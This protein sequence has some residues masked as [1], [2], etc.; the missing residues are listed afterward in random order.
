MKKRILLTFI[1]AVTVAI[2]GCGQQMNQSASQSSAGNTEE[3]AAPETAAS[4]AVTEMD[5][6][7]MFTGR[8]YEVGYKESESAEILLNETSAACSSDAV[9]ISGSTVTITE[10]GT[11]ILR[12][13]LENG[14]VIVDADETDK[15]QLVFDGVSIH[16]ETSAP[17]YILEA[18][19]V[20]ITLP[21]D[22]VNT[23][24]NGGVFTAIDDN[25]IDAAVFSKQDLT[26]NGSGSLTVA[27]PAGHG[28][29][30]KDDLVFT[31][32]T[33]AIDAASHGIDANDSIRITNTAL[34]ITSGKDGIHGENTDD[35]SL[36][37]VYIADGTFHITAE[38]DGLSASSNMQIEDGSFAI[39]AGGGSVNAQKQDSGFGGGFQGGGHRRSDSNTGEASSDTEEESISMKGIKAESNLVVHNGTFNIDAADDAVHSNTSITINGG[40]FEI[41]SGDDGFHADETMTIMAGTINIS[42][43][44]EGLEGL[45]VVI[46]GGDVH[47]T[48]SDDGINAAGGT[49]QSGF[50]GPRGNDRFGGGMDNRD[51]SE[52]GSILISG[53][54]LTVHASGDGLDANGTLT[55]SGGVIT[56]SC[57]TSGDTAVLDYDTSGEMTGGSFIG[58]GASAMAQ[59]FG[60][61]G[62]GVISINAGTQSAGTEITL[63]DADGNTVISYEA[64]Q[65]FEIVILSSPELVKGETYTVKLGDSSA[66]FTVE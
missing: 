48:A 43:S 15:I 35:S 39:I 28:I 36:G 63:M 22:S 14:M 66:E 41:V 2:A 59:T 51:S 46:S 30:C 62:Q 6:S 58:T 40:S 25:N 56:V 45:H 13:T 19:K 26:F 47:V 24:S 3:T 49:D 37:F 60:T 1:L 17:I 8:D 12:G 21:S 42:E 57:P 38:G 61:S 11:Y 31:S 4:A 64:D 16:N 53:G 52:S 29:V 10:E 50:G 54:N 34:T 33:Y 20:F 5:A 55:V 44:Y 23:L 9:Q 32:G 7:E 65:S 18:D 27:S